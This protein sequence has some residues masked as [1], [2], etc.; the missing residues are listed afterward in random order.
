MADAADPVPGTT[1]GTAPAPGHPRGSRRLQAIEGGRERLGP[2][3]SLVRLA[4]EDDDSQRLVTAAA[5]ELRQPIGLVAPTGEPLGH[6]PDD[7]A[8]RRALTIAAAIAARATATVPPG[9]RVVRLVPEHSRR[10]VLAVGTDPCAARDVEPLLDL[11]V[12][13]LGDQ[14]V[15]AALRRRQ[16][17]SFLRRLVSEPGLAAVRAREEGSAVGLELPA[18]YW[19]AVLSWD[20][21]PPAA[22]IVERVDREARRLHRGGL[23]AA[24]N[25]RMV[26]LHPGDGGASSVMS[27]LEQVVAQAG[28]AAPHSRPHVVAGDAPVALED[29]GASVARL[30]R[31]SGCGPR[32]EPGRPVAAAR[33]YALER[34]LGEALAPE[35]ARSFVDDLLGGLIAWD[36]EHR[37]DLLR[38]L[39][40]ALDSHRHDQ[41]AHRCYMHRNTFRVRLRKALLVLGDDLEDPGVRLAVHVALKLRH[42]TGRTTGRSAPNTANDAAGTG[43]RRPADAAMAAAAPPARRW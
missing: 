14:L 37:S 12:A 11:I 1:A 10:A 31:L 30:R 8:G 21:G 5:A 40:A 15:R 18:A 7:A 22:D 29:L 42:V 26:L 3:A 24:S 35:E 19:P 16:T 38:V 41:A 2:V 32:A 33:Q 17:A 4:V 9:W 36:R 25:G 43:R 39:E 6:A 23:T 34:L 28:R 20:A 27:W 13:L